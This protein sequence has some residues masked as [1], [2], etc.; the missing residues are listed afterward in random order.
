[1]TDFTRAPGRTSCRHDSRP[2]VSQEWG[3]WSAGL[4]PDFEEELW[5][6]VVDAVWSPERA[7][8]SA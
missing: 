8:A 6:C 1:M 3:P 4:R 7:V 5:I 2:V